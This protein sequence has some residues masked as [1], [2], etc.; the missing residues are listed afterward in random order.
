MNVILLFSDHCPVQRSRQFLIYF[1]NLTGIEVFSILLS[2][3]KLFLISVKCPHYWPFHCLMSNSNHLNSGKIV[4]ADD[5]FLPKMSSASMMTLSF[6]WNHVFSNWDKE[7]VLNR[8][9]DFRSYCTVDQED[10]VW[11]RIFQ[12]PHLNKRNKKKEKKIVISISCCS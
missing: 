9:E 12:F 2:L 5:H 10:K 6:L 1:D 8:I 11:E 3:D 4:M 7:S